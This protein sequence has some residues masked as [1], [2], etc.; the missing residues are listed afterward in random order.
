MGLILLMILLGKIKSWSPLSVPSGFFF[1]F[2]LVFFFLNNF[3][4]LRNPKWA[5]PP[6]KVG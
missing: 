6:W 4:G 3:T 1:S 5:A 2:L